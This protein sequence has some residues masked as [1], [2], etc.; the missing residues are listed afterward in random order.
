MNYVIIS[1]LINL[2]F[3]QSVFALDYCEKLLLEKNSAASKCK[4][5]ADQKARTDC[6]LEIVEKSLQQC[7]TIAKAEERNNCIVEQTKKLN[8]EW[9]PECI[10]KYKMELT[11][12]VESKEKEKFGKSSYEANAERQ[13]AFKENQLKVKKAEKQIP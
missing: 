3:N 6:G 10:Q 7:I 9:P 5:I 13:K 1:F 4:N 12:R 2:F 8:S 11:K